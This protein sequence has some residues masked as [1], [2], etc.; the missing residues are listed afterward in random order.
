VGRDGVWE[1]G[2]VGK[3]GGWE[4]GGGSGWEVLLVNLMM[5]SIYTYI[6]LFKPYICR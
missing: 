2:E 6:Y 1:R 3:D 5:P 4:R